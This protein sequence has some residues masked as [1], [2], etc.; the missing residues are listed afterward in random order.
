MYK[1]FLIYSISLLIAQIIIIKKNLIANNLGLIDKPD[2]KRKIHKDEVPLIGGIYI[3]ASFIIY[4]LLFTFFIES[5]QI[6]FSLS[7]ILI[8][9]MLFMIGLLDD[10]IKINS[11]SRIF[12]IIL[13]TLLACSIT[14][15][16][17]INQIFLSF[18]KPNIPININIFFTVFCILVLNIAINLSDGS[19]GV[20]SSLNLV[21]LSLF[22]YLIFFLDK[23]FFYILLLVIISSLIFLTY[24]LSNKCF[25]GSAG[26]NTL[27]GITAFTAIYLNNLT[28]IYADTIVIFFLIPGL[29]MCRVIVY[30]IL[31]KKN[32]FTPDR[33]HLHHLLEKILNKNMIF[34]FYSLLV[35]IFCLVSLFY[36]KFNFYII[37]IIIILYGLLIY[38]LKNLRN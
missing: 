16:F 14:K 30:R 20:T 12:L 28:K 27:S 19:N 8:I 11:L 6:R 22:C 29:D 3:F 26:C 15:D 17:Q 31:Q 38:Y 24:N 9:S 36:P 18:F 35:L 4:F 33:N 34:I 32:P 21:W 7:L 23:N 1:L 37:F 10:I 25:L 2:N 5:Y 13:A